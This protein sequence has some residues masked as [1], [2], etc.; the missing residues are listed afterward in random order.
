MSDLFP[1]TVDD[2]EKDPPS[3]VR[4]KELINLGVPANIGHLGVGDYQ[5]IVQREEGPLF[6][7]VE[8]KSI[9]D[10]LSSAAD[11]RLNR[12]ID[13]TGGVTPDADLVRAM[14]IEGNQFVFGSYGYK[15]WTPEQVDNILVSFQALGVLVI[16]SPNA[17]ATAA[18][19]RSY[20]L[21]TGRD[22]HVSLLKVV[23]PEITGNYLNGGKKQAVR[24]LMGLPGWGETLSRA[25]VEALG[26][27]ESV[28]QAVTEGDYKAFADVKGIGKGKVLTAQAFLKENYVSR[29]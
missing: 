15:E 23:R 14:L 7:V 13:E 11:G 16:R 9:S 4:V 3:A 28:I 8:R 19:L 6:V 20:W 17:N 26:S 2:R 12:F 24:F 27:A 1:I 22:D 21:Y 5:W 25:A 18:R 29:S 10:L